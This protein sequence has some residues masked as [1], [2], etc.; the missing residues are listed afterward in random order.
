LVARE[1]ER[2]WEA[3]L[4]HE[5]HE[6][7]EYARFRR[8]RPVAL[9]ADERAAI[10]RLA[11]DVPGRWD[12]PEMTP[13][14][15]QEIVRTLLERITVDGQGDSEQVEVTLHGAGGVTSGQRLRRPVSRDDQLSHYQ[16]LLTR[17]GELHRAGHNFVHIAAYLNREGFSPPKRTQR[18]TGS[19]V[20]R[21]LR[22]RGLHGLRPRAQGEMTVL[23]LHEYWLTEVARRVKMPIATLHKW[24]RLG[25]VHSRK[26]AVAGGRW[27]IWADLSE[28]ERLRRLR[29]YKRKWPESHYPRELPTPKPRTPERLFVPRA[30]L[31]T[32]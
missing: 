15:R 3:A 29:A 10:L 32:W 16:V 23:P 22:Q 20:A 14:D 5:Q 21:L 26:V 11:E 12:A 9:T 2:L 6:Q 17:I 1:L 25:W 13:Q 28:L 24:Q 18:F 30:H 27:A 19:I 31:F 4:R 7:E 8:E